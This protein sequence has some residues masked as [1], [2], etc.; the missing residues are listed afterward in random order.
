MSEHDD[1]LR[2]AEIAVIDEFPS[3]SSI[4]AARIVQTAVTVYEREKWVTNMQRVNTVLASERQ[5]NAT[6]KGETQ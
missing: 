4:D 3:L 6:N 5:V 1:W 2:L